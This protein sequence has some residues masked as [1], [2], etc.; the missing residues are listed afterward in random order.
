M[1]ERS[2]SKFSAP[3]FSKSYFFAKSFCTTFANIFKSKPLVNY[4]FEKNPLSPEFRGEIML[5]RYPNGEER[6]VACKLCEAVCPAQ[7][8]I[9]RGEEGADGRPHATSF[10]VNMTQ[11]ISCGLCEEACPVE[12]IALGPNYE[13]STETKAELVYD[14]EKLL[15]NGDRWEDAIVQRRDAKNP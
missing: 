3:N 11:C 9:V 14:K 12:A 7:A 13:Y 6:C 1:L 4:P 8:I 5:R 2:M 15:S 10:Q